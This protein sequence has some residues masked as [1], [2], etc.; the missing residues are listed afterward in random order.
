MITVR[1]RTFPGQATLMPAPETGPAPE[2][3]P[4]AGTGLPARTGPAPETGLATV[5]R[6]GR[7]VAVVEGGGPEPPLVVVELDGDRIEE[8]VLLDLADLLGQLTEV[9]GVLVER[10]GRPYGI[11]ARADVAAALPLELLEEGSQRLGGAPGLPSR[12]YVCRKCEPPSRRLPRSATN[13]PPA[14]SRVWSH[15]PMELEGG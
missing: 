13:G 15:G 8:A 12:R 11:V 2:P 9:P 6:D 10:D 14:C 3:G 1:I 5:T 4:S 7:V